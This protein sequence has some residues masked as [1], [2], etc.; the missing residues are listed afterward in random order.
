MSTPV[1]SRSPNFALAEV[2]SLFQPYARPAVTSATER[3]S[4][5]GRSSGARFVEERTW[6]LKFFR[7]GD[8]DTGRV[9]APSI[10]LALTPAGLGQEV[11]QLR[12]ERLILLLV[13][14]H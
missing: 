6:G 7:L 8:P 14:S 9:P 10:R 4:A 5:R 2:R 12:K 11:F 13:S 1:T 3:R